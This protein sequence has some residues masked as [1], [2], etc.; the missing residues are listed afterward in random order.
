MKKVKSKNLVAFNSRPPDPQPVLDDEGIVI[1]PNLPR[2]II[3]VDELA[4]IMTPSAKD[5][6]EQSICRIAQKGRA[7]GIHL[8]IATNSLRRSIVTDLIKANIPT[9]IVFRVGSE[10][11]SRLILDCN[12]AEKL[13]GDGDMLFIPPGSISLERIQGAHVSEDELRRVVDAVSRNTGTSG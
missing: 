9:K 10:N 11:E 2:M 8:V 13:L 4:D 12:G 5:G 6:V 1:P 3:I 7:A